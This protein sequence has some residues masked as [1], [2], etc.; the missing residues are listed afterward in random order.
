MGNGFNPDGVKEF[1]LGQYSA[2]NWKKSLLEANMSTIIY[3]VD[4]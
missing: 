1:G 2:Q 4:N 3:S